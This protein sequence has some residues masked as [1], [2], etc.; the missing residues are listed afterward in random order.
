MPGSDPVD[1]TALIFTERDVYMIG[2]YLAER[3]DVEEED[4]TAAIEEAIT[5]VLS[6]PF[7]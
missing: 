4:V 3:W 1:D 6:S 7:R 5:A 2:G